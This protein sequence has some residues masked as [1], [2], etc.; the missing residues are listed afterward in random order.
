MATKSSQEKLPQTVTAMQAHQLLGHPSYQAIEH[1]QDSTT[2]L[3]VGTHSNGRQWNDDCIPCI[4]GKMKEDI[5]R[6]PRADKACRLFYRII[7]DIIQ[8]QK[9]SEA[10]YN[11]DVWALHAVCEY[12][13]LYEIY[14]LKDRQKATVVPAIT[15]LVNKIERVYGY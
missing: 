8:L 5:S 6:R 15:R 1:L 4:Q 11:S 7:V 2:G 13:K 12:T 3:N 9:H 14:T 10:C